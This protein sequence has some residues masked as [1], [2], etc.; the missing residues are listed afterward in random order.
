VRGP[1]GDVGRCGGVLRGSGRE[2]ARTQASRRRCPGVRQVVVP[3]AREVICDTMARCG[4]LVAGCGPDRPIA[5][6]LTPSTM[7]VCHALAWKRDRISPGPSAASAFPVICPAASPRPRPR[8]PPP[9]PCPRFCPRPHPFAAVG[10]A[11]NRVAVSTPPAPWSM[12][13]TV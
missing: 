10:V 9:P 3:H 7:A 8:R 12:S 2:I 6:A 5:T 11:V 1:D 4:V 13:E